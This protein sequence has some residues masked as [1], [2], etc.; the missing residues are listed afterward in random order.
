MVQAGGSRGA[1]GSNI[2]FILAAAGSAIGLGNIWG[3]PYRASQSGGGAFVLLYLLCVALVGLPV[4]LAELSIGRAAQKSPVGAFTKLAPRSWW[5]LAG[6][7][8]VL[9]GFVILSFYAAIAGWAVGYL[10]KAV[11]GQF[12]R[13]LDMAQSEAIFDGL[14][15]SPLLSILWTSIFFLLTIL[16]VRGGIKG[17]IEKASKILMPIFFLFLVG[18]VIRSVTLPGSGEGVR[19]LFNTDFH[20]ITPR[21]VL[22]ALGQAFF[23]MSLGMGAMMTY[24]SYLAKKE[25]LAFSGTT[26]AVFDTGIALLAGLMIFPA[27]FASGASDPQVGDEGLVFV[28]LPTIFDKIPAG[29][30]FAVGFYSL[31]VIAALTSAISLLEVIVS[32]FVD[33]RGWSRERAAWL[34][35]GACWVMALGCA[36][37]GRF[38]GFLVHLTYNYV[39]LIGGFIIC[40]FAGWRWG[41]RSAIGEMRAEGA[42]FPGLWFWGFLVRFVCPALIGL[43]VVH[44]IYQEFVGG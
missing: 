17:G 21:I 19:F 1:F 25:N 22:D 18:L 13:G 34:M 8:G 16:V 36:L 42:A 5:P 37:S 2:G 12:R 4:L 31:L 28:V 10:Y 43:I 44:H 23:S 39:L 11:R 20:K 3:F 29:G 26:V 32:Y 40:L 14:R 9:T 24:G 30:V 38:M 15:A 33:E 27:L 7:M 35:G 6:G 41:I